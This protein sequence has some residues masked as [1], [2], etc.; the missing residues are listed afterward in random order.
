VAGGPLGAIDRSGVR[1]V[2]RADSD[3]AQGAVGIDA[4]VGELDL[5]AEQ[6]G[7][8]GSN[9]PAVELREC[10]SEA[11][12]SGLEGAQ[13]GAGTVARLVLAP[14]KLVRRCSVGLQRG[15]AYRC[16]VLDGAAVL[17]AERD[18]LG[19]EHRPAGCLGERPHSEPG[20]S[21]RLVPRRDQARMSLVSIVTRSRKPS[22]LGSILQSP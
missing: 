2:D 21:P 19:V 11:V 5:V 10:L 13:R 22:H 16:E 18:E 7:E 9:T 12:A 6:R 8:P 3:F 14:V 17:G 4:R 15:S 1:D 20:R